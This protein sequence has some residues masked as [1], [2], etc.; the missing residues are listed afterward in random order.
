MKETKADLR[1][2]I[3]RLELDRAG[4]YSFIKLEIDFAN[5]TVM[6][7]GRTIVLPTD[8]PDVLSIPVLATRPIVR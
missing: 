5:R 8:G 3:A 4:S 1:R 2:R 6:Y 7:D